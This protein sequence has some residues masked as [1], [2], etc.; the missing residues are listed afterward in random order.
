MHR[1]NIDRDTGKRAISRRAVLKQGALAATALAFGR[2]GRAF[3]A[4]PTSIPQVRLNNGVM[5]P[6]L[7]FGTYS[8]KG[9]LCTESVAD[10]IAAGYRLIDTAKV[11][12]NEEAV[13][14]GI[15]KSGIDRKSLFVTS[16]I[17][18]DDS[19]Y[20]QAK[21]A[22]Q[23]TLD[24]LQLEYLDLYLIHRP[25]GDVQGS[26]RAMEELN[27]AGKIRAIGLSNFDPTQLAG[28][29]ANAKTKPAINQIETHPFFQETAEFDSLH[30][31][32]VQMEAWAPFAEGRNGL[33]TNPVLAQ[34]AQ[35]H[36][37]TVAQVVLRWHNQ[38]GVIA[39]PRSSNPEHRRE[40]LA[41][42]DFSLD[43]DDTRRIAALDENKSQ[44]PEWT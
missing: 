8:L 28:I 5:M 15:K 36:N 2:I 11:Y 9:D 37:K 12:Q 25:R 26:W 40:N 34:I 21:R 14:A 39:I 4:E 41:I 7:G 19:G 1:M 20:E 31:A 3:A 35:K 33:F 22:F 30:T 24:K 16:K 10:A 44:F 13:G 38:R 27:A 6:V 29:T 23:T 18:V 32:G 42:F 43:A 17:W